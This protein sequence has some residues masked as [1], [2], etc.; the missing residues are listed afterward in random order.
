MT[1][2]PAAYRG[3]FQFLGGVEGSVGATIYLPFCS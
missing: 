1:Q 3:D 2:P